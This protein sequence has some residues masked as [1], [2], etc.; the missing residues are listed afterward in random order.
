[1]AQQKLDHTGNEQWWRTVQRLNEMFAELYASE[2]AE[3]AAT[4]SGEATSAAL[5]TAAGAQATITITNASIAATS[6]VFVALKNG[7]NS[8]GAPVVV[9]V[10]PGAGSAAVVIQNIHAS[11]AL[12]G[13]LKAEYFV[14]I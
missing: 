3:V 6:K 9:T 13:T 7:T 11:A 12:N 8:A 14:V 4:T 2:A 5:T 10:T 1:M